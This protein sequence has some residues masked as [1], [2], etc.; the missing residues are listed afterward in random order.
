MVTDELDIETD[1]VAFLRGRAPAGMAIGPSTPLLTGGLLDSL[2][3]LELAMLIEQR[4]GIPLDDDAFEASNF[5]TLASL[6][7]Y[8]ERRRRG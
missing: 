2:A 5:E 6:L 8:V 3:I 1:I 4:A 7:A